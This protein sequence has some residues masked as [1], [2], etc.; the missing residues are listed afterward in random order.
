MENQPIPMSRAMER[1]ESTLAGFSR[2]S[3]AYLRQRL[4]YRVEHYFSSTPRDW[5]YWN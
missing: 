1:L 3:A 4:F 5:T 2:C